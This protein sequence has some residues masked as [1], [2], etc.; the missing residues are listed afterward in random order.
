M[1]NRAPPCVPNSLYTWRHKGWVQGHVLKAWGGRAFPCVRVDL[2]CG[3]HV[4]MYNA[5]R[6]S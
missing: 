4:I 3:T 5:Q 2:S 1:N 6:L